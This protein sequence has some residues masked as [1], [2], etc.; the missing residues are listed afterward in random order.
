MTVI[1]PP[2]TDKTGIDNLLGNLKKSV[3][4]DMNKITPNEGFCYGVSKFS[5][6]DKNYAE[7][8]KR[9]D[10][11]LYFFKTRDCEK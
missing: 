4:D 3:K 5:T 1:V 11:Q 7:I 2:E 6:T 8:L 9:A 10:E